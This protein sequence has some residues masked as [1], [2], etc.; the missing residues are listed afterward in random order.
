MCAARRTE[1]ARLEGPGGAG[2]LPL[3]SRERFLV[4]DVLVNDNYITCLT[5]QKHINSRPVLPPSLFF[6][7]RTPITSFHGM[8]RTRY[9]RRRRRA[10]S[11]REAKAIKAIS[12]TPVET[13]GIYDWIE[14]A[15]TR[16]VSGV[17]VGTFPNDRL[18]HNQAQ[19]RYIVN[20]FQ[21]MPREGTIVAGSDPTVH[22]NEFW[23][24]GIKLRFFTE[25]YGPRNYRWRISLV[26]TGMYRASSRGTYASN[27]VANTDYELM[28]AD[29]AFFEPTVQPFNPE[30]V[31]IL[32]QWNYTMTVDGQT[33]KVRNMYYRFGS[34]KTLEL[35]EGAGTTVGRLSGRNYY[36]IYEWYT[37]VIGA[38]VPSASDFMRSKLEWTNYIKDP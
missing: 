11:K 36:L 23:A 13:V 3:L 22:G 8:A 10:F 30:N 5:N 35:P 14:P 24:V 6:L 12:K 15:A 27:T 33:A 19:A 1:P 26:S 18:V 38:Y 34:K 7:F 2:G 37:P 4:L 25:V 16:Y 32:R 21:N 9:Y 17:T 20:I 28:K 29:T 31:R